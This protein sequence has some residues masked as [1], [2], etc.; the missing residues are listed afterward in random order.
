[1]SRLEV[2][3]HDVLGL[4]AANPSPFTLT[5]TNSWVVGREPAWLIDPGPALEDHLQAISAEIE[6]RGGL[7]GVALTH[8]HA[9]HAQAVPFIR[10]RY[11]GIPVAAARGDV[12][13]RLEDG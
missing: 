9:D 12:D 8:D 10:E 3:G 7:G 1:M 4:T 5:G 11:P 6:L 13:V 2:P